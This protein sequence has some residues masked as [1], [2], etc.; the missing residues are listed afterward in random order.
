MWFLFWHAYF[1]IAM[2]VAA[3]MGVHMG[4]GETEKELGFKAMGYGLFAMMFGFVWP[5]VM[6]G[7][8]VAALAGK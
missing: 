7:T 6:I 5:V 2:Y 8:F 1:M 4:C 3:V